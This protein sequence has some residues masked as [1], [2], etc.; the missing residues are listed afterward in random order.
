M[1]RGLLSA[2]DTDCIIDVRRQVSSL[3]V[4]V[5][6]GR[7]SMPSEPR[8]KP[9]DKVLRMSRKIPTSR[10]PVGHE[11]KKKKYL[12][13]CLLEQRRHHFSPLV[14]ELDVPTSPVTTS[15]QESLFSKSE[16]TLLKGSPVELLQWISSV[17]NA[18][19]R[20]PLRPR[21]IWKP[22]GIY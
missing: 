22:K 11:R 18:T 10:L 1:L 13:A 6:Y 9:P 4:P 19:R 3:P 21:T 5:A 17:L 20:A 7:M 14:D 2:R 12:E 15:F 16:V 8:S